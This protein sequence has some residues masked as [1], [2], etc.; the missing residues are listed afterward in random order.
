VR[1]LIVTQWFDPEPAFK[2]L[3]LAQQLVSHGHKVEVLTGFPNYPQGKLYPG[4]RM[5]L[6]QKEL[7]GGIPVVRVPLYPSHDR[8]AVRRA[9]NYVS[10]AATAAILGPALVAKPDVIYVYHPPGTVG[11]PAL[12]LRRW[13]RVPV[14]YDVQDLW[15]DTIA[16]TGMLRQVQA[17]R[18]VDGLCRFV[19]RHVDSVV[20]QSPGFRKALMARGAAA[21]SLRVIYNWAPRQTANELRPYTHDGGTFTIVFAGTM[22]IAQ[23]LDTVLDAAQE[24][25]QTV[26]RARFVLI[27]DGVDLERLKR[28]AVAMRLPNLE[29]L[30]RQSLVATQAIL[31][32]AGTLLVHLKDD[33][34]FAITIPSKTQAYLASGR[35]ILMAVR[36]DAA[37]L[38][39]RAGAGILAQPGDSKSIAAAVR[40]LAEM[41]EEQRERMGRAGR[42]FYDAELAIEHAV[43][44]FETVFQSTCRIDTSVGSSGIYRK[45]GKRLLD[46][47]VS[48]IALAMLFPLMVA[49]ALAIRTTMG[50]PVFFRQPRPGKNGRILTLWKFRT[51]SEER[52]PDGEL[53]PESR[54]V[55]RIGRVL[56]SASL[57]ELPEL[58]NVFRG[59]M[60]L[61]GPRP[62]LPEYLPRYSAE[63]G[64]RHEVRPGI[65]GLAQISGRNTTTW[66]RRLEL[67]VRYVDHYN[68]ALDCLILFRTF[69]A[70][71]RGDG[72]PKAMEKLG[73]FGGAASV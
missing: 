18:L 39:V 15:P 7:V 63:Q 25:V 59:D 20:V 68:F 49:V 22:G 62:L 69:A 37:D 57:D 67:D 54:R 16:A 19:Y 41:P 46:V 53:M 23:G 48:G 11:F 42:E 29:F 9:L 73:R 17:I 10:F 50:S 13:F 5:R 21:D 27:G 52:R 32:G 60:S 51:M 72:G 70:V 3:E 31:A 6:W 45:F 40:L 30:G 66:D 65:S 38:V 4:Y 8:S 12:V 2:C 56:R 24:C 55:T 36:G 28:R 44:K 58:W 33:P 43:E 26:P 64:R 14:V 1:I 61:V 47:V 35:P 71:L 34:L